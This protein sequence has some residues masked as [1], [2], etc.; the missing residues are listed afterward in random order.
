MSRFDEHLAIR[1]VFLLCGAGGVFR[2]RDPLI[3]CFPRLH[4][5]LSPKEANLQ[6]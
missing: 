5:V 1:R 2:R 4:S 3:N 6:S